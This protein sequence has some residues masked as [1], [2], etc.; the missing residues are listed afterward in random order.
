MEIIY[1]KVVKIKISK[2][3]IKEMELYRDSFYEIYEKEEPWDIE[4]LNEMLELGRNFM[5]I[6]IDNYK[7]ENA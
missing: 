7:K 5:E 4:D 3:D 2:S 1:E 6:F